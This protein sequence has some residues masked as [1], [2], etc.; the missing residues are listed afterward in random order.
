MKKILLSLMAVI[1]ITL[2]ILWFNYSKIEIDL[3]DAAVKEITDS[4]F[5]VKLPLE[6]EEETTEQEIEDPEIEKKQ[7]TT[8]QVDS[9]QIIDDH[10]ESI[11]ESNSNNAKE[12]EDNSITTIKQNKVTVNQIKGRYMPVF[13]DLERQ[14]NAKLDQLLS[15]AYQEYKTKKKNGEEISYMYFYKKYSSAG[16]QLESNTDAAFQQIYNALEQELDQEGFDRA[17]AKEFRNIY[18]QTKKER[19]SSILNNAMG[20]F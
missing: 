7:P 15:A 18:E 12:T 19:R 16:L 14:S 1:A 17:E 20:S 11:S 3:N 4:N 10:N 5:E 2:G 6:I 13:K 8:S 9:T